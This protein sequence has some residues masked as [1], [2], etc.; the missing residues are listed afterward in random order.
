MLKFPGVLR[1]FSNHYSSCLQP[2][3]LAYT[4]LKAFYPIL[5]FLVFGSYGFIPGVYRAPS[6]YPHDSLEAMEID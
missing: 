4:A 1:F 5:L 3:V 6:L 2:D